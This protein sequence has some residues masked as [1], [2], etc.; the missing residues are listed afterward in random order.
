MNENVV[1]AQGNRLIGIVSEA[2]QPLADKPIIV[3]LNA[4]LLHK[5]GPF[6]FYVKLARKLAQ[7]G[8]TVCRFDLSSIGDSD[9]SADFKNHD[10]QVV[11]DVATMLDRLG[12]R[13]P[14]NRFV[15]MGLCTGAD[16]AHRSLVQDPR[17]VGALFWDGYGY[18]TKQFYLRRYGPILFSPTRLMAL[19]KKT[20]GWGQ[21]QE[22]PLMG[23]EE[24]V[25]FN[26]HLPEKSKTL[27]ELQG[28]IQRKVELFYIFTGG[29]NMYYNYEN[30]FRESFSELDF[31][32]RLRVDYMPEA[33]HTYI[34]NSD[35]ENV[36][37]RVESWLQERF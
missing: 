10:I 28:F 1:T 11:K 13:Y 18:P 8:Y 36:I 32:D 33:D 27:V 31:A 34:L 16:I 35:Q 21:T 12:K 24:S 22:D 29:V 4:G 5:V 3:L 17:I 19:I 20:F 26:W 7:Q 14:S 30:Q 15:L 9:N 6:R 23:I 25:R 2:D 37:S